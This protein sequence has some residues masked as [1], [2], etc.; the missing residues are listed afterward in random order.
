MKKAISIVL[1]L[2]LVL[3]LCACQPSQYT[4]SIKNARGSTERI[5]VDKL[6]GKTFEKERDYVEFL[7]SIQD[8]AVWGEATVSSATRFG[9]LMKIMTEEGLEIRLKVAQ[10]SELHEQLGSMVGYPELYAGDTLR[11]RGIIRET[12]VYVYINPD[13]PTLRYFEEYEDHYLELS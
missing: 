8:C 9:S 4:F 10:E 5:T 6:H 3:S 7:E 13:D 1:A 11:F 12:W 2:V